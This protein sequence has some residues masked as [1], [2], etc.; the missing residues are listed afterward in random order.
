MCPGVIVSIEAVELQTAKT[1]I[2]SRFCIRSRVPNALLILLAAFDK[3][4]FIKQKLMP[5]DV[6]QRG[7]CRLRRDKA[8]II[9]K[10]SH[11]RL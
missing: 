4:H 10:G 3:F 11:F 9:V 8:E 1:E 2:V 7:A 6:R 5:S